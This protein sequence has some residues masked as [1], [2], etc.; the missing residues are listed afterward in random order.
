MQ[1]ARK[2]K[3]SGLGVAMSLYCDFPG[4]YTRL[5]KIGHLWLWLKKAPKEK[6]L[7]HS[8][9][10]IWNSSMHA[11]VHTTNHGLFCEPM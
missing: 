3:S 1:V 2:I 8:H 7:V 4:V 9:V 10:S 6:I 11:Q 5:L